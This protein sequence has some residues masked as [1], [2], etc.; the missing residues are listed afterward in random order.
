MDQL[1]DLATKAGMDPDQGKAAS[2]GILSVLKT[3][4]EGQDFDKIVANIPGASTAVEEHEASTANDAPAS[5]MAGMMGAAM[6]SLGGSQ[7]ASMAGLL[8]TLQNKGIDPG[9]MQKYMTS[10]APIIQEKCGVDI[11]KTLGLPSS[12]SGGETSVES[13]DASGGGDGNS[14]PLSSL[15]GMAKGFGF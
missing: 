3:A 7:G 1:L 9:M 15:S 5:G 2:G 13:G 10:V 12:D 11:T 14:N 8:A 6:S 4:M